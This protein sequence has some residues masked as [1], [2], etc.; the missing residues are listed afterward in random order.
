M[1]VEDEAIYNFIAT[2]PSWVTG[3]FAVAVF[4]GL[5][6]STALVARKMWAR[7]MLILSLLA[8]LVQHF[9]TFVLSD[10]LALAGPMAAIS[11]IA[12]ITVAAFEIWMA[13]KG[14]KRGW[15]R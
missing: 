15:L 12:V 13:H 4:A 5:V 8:V 14:I 2:V 7:S 6:G 10:Y 11:P 9:W 3:A 1:Q